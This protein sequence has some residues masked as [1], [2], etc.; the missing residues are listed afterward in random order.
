MRVWRELVLTFALLAASSAQAEP[1]KVEAINAST[2]T[3]CAE[4]DNVFVKFV[5]PLVRALRIEA[6]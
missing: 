1:L 4:T 6:V 3:Q 5:S 2:P